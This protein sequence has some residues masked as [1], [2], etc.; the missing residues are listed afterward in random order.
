MKIGTKKS[1]AM[2]LSLLLLF[3]IWA[4]GSVYGQESDFTPEE[5]DYIKEHPV[6]ITAVDPM[7][8]PYEFI[9]SD[10]N[11]KGMAADYLKLIEVKTGL[12]FQILAGLTWPEAY[13]MALNGQVD[14]LPCIGITNER[15]T[16]FLFT[17]GYFKYQRA[18][19]SLEDSPNY[20]FSD[21]DEI[22]VG[23]Q[24]NSSHYSFISYETDIEPVLYED[25]ES[26]ITALSLGE[27]DAIVANYASA[28]YLAGQLGITNIKADEIIDSE[29][30]E[31]GMAVNRDK[32]ILASILN[33]ALSK[34]SEEEKILIRNKWLG[35]EK[36]ADYSLIY[37]YIIIG[38]IIAAAVILIFVFWNRSLKKHVEER[39]EAEQ[40]IKLILESAG[41]GI[42]GVDTSGNVNFINPAA[43]ALL[44]YEEHEMLGRQI[45]YLIH[46]SRSDLTEYDINNCPMK[47]T[48]TLGEKSHIKDEILWQKSG[49]SVRRGIYKCT[50]C[51]KR[52][53]TRRGNSFQGHHRKQKTAGANQKGP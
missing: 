47:K 43:L 1:A 11:Y 13:E 17:E 5:L 48:Y 31:L 34:I 19:F 37:R 14:L 12:T 36:E 41:E 18:I 46:H 50:D 52:R 44:G 29:T 8:Q 32:P 33:K 26:L 35:I 24:R 49:T 10:G 20:K 38:S 3:A 51:Q 27:I 45:H 16:L 6:V 2:V 23:V 25:A 4:A 28:K 30:S 21:L 15:Q 53:N 7:F 22:S 9:D 42:I 40:K 39:K